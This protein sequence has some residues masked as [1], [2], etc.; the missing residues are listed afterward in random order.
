MKKID[1]FF[2]NYLI[3]LLFNKQNIMR[4]TKKRK[5]QDMKDFIVDDI[6]DNDNIDNINDNYKKSKKQKKTNFETKYEELQ[7]EVLKREID[8]DDIFI[9]NLPQNENIWFYE[10]IKIRD[11][12][13]SDSEEYYNIKTQIYEKYNSLKN[14][15]MTNLNK[16]KSESHVDDDVV[17]RILNSDHDDT[18]KTILYKKYKRCYDNV[19]N[20]SDEMFKVL[21]W[22]D[23]ILD[24]PTKVGENNTSIS[25]KLT[26]LWK[27]LNDNVFGLLSVKEK[28]MET[29]CAKL[30]DPDNKG[31]ILVFV[32]PPGVGKTAMAS[33]IA[34]AL[35]M[36]FDQISFGSLKDSTILTGHS[37]TY[38]GSIPGMFTKILLKS[39]RLD[40]VVLLDEIDKIPDTPE[41]KSISSVLLHVLDRSQNHR[42]KD[43]YMP[44][45]SLD[46]SK[47]IFLCAANS[48]DNIDSAL[49][50]RMTIINI[51][52]YN[53]DEKT[54]IALKY[55][56]PKISKELG[57]SENELVIDKDTMTY[58]IT[59]KTE[60]REGMREVERQIYQ[61][62]ERLSLLKYA[63]SIP[64]SFKMNNIS[65]PHKINTTTLDKL[66]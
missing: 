13:H 24:L 52:G 40:T 32:G 39:K 2:H 23:N 64:F 38:I 28:V 19:T 46:L 26:K 7:K 25:D 31:K 44:E 14:V 49:F 37:S 61:L 4:T 1:I 34:N 48:L 8:M 53:V 57:F 22:I 59:Q 62:C 54:N 29:V 60:H 50:D 47:M 10:H 56:F 12:F 45:I 15:D 27:T 5:N 42:F 63:K 11:A 58:L 41:G 43:M 33:A 55:L 3:V 21:E 36:P 30:L 35:E 9:L 66:L 16:I 17:T 51:E 20:A 6:D 65:F 18:V